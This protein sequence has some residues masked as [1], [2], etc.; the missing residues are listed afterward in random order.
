MKILHVHDIAFVASNFVSG[1]NE[2]GVDATLYEI[3]KFSNPRMPDFVSLVINY[4]LRFIEL[5]RFRLFIKQNDFDIVHIHFG[6]FSYLA[7]LNNIPFYLHVHGTDVRKFIN[8]PFL[9][10]IIKAGIKKAIRVFYS[11]PDLEAL[12]DPYRIDAIFLPNPIDTEMFKSLEKNFY[13]E[14]FDVFV[15]SKIDKY[16]GYIEIIR[17]LEILW[18]MMPKMKVLLFGF[19]NAMSEELEKNINS[20]QKKR[21]L[22]VL[23]PI[24]HEKV[25]DFLTRSKVIFGQLGTGILTCSELEAMSCGKAVVCNFSYDGSYPECPPI[26]CAHDHIEA[27][28]SIIYLLKNERIRNKIGE[29]ARKWVEGYADRYIISKQILQMYTSDK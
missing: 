26:V 24:P 6:T 12:I 8:Y 11:T 19:G 2:V 18:Q 15:V 7:T 21:S 20:L 25:P 10:L 17:T 16:K 1:L 22:K 5:F 14:E 28:D 27:K 13:E 23:N 3:R 9:G 4:F 29:K